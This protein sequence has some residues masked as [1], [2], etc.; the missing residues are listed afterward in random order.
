MPSTFFGLSI[1]NSGL[2][3]SQA[4]LNTTAHNIANIET[5]GFS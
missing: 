5:E 2:Y 3:A 1:G 4:G